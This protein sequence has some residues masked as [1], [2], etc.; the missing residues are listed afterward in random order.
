MDFM[1]LADSPLPTEPF[2][3]FKGYITKEQKDAP[4]HMSAIEF[5]GQW[6][7]FYQ[8]GNVNEGTFHRRSAC[9][10]E[11]EFNEDGTNVPIEYTLDE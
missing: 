3:E 10:E 5:K 7:F 6:Y 11:M 9:F 2:A 1:C 8:R 4:L